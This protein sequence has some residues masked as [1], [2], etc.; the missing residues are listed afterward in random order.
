MEPRCLLALDTAAGIGLTAQYFAG[1]DFQ[2][3]L[4]TRIES[5][6]TL[7]WGNGAPVAG[8]NPDSFSARLTGQVEA[9]VTEAHTFTLSADGGVRLWVNGIKHIDRWNDLFVTGATATVDLISGRR[10]DIQ[11]EFRDTSGAANVDLKWS[12]PSLS[13]QAIPTTSLFPAELGSV[14]RRVWNS[15]PGAN[16]SALTSLASFPNSPSAV[17]TLSTFEFSSTGSDSYGDLISGILH[18]QAT[19]NYRFFIAGDDSA[20]LWLSNTADPA[21]KQRIAFLTAATAVRDWTVNPSQQSALIPLVAGQQYAIEVIHKENTGADH[22]AVGW[23]LPGST[24]IDVIDGQFLSPLLALVR[25]FS[26]TDVTT[27]GSITPL[28]Y[29]VQRG[30]GPSTNPLVVSYILRGTATAELDYAVTS[31]TVTIPAGAN[32]A[33]VNVTTLND[34]DT[35]GSETVIFEVVDGLGYEVG[36]ISER[37]S[38]GT[39]QDVVAVPAGGIV[40]TATDTLANYSKFGGTFQTIT[41]ATPFSTAVQATI[42]AVLTNSYDAQLKLGFG[43]AVQQGDILF[44][45]FYVRSVTGSEGQIT[46]VSEK[47][48]SPYTK[49]L[50]QSFAVP[51]VWTHVQLPFTSLENYAAGGASFGFFLGSKAQTL[52]FTNVSV[53]NYGAARNITPTTVFLNNIGGTYGTSISVPVTGQPF[54]SAVQLDTVTT[55]DQ[56]FKLQYVGRNSAS[57]ATGSVLQLEY[58][59]RSLSGATPKVNLSI[60]EVGGAYTTLASHTENLTPTWTKYTLNVTTSSV[61]SIEG[62]QAAFNVGFAPQTIEIGGVKWTNT[63]GTIDLANLPS[64]SPTA[65][66]VGRTGDDPWRTT[67]DSRI[68]DVRKAT[69]TVNVVDAKGNPVDGAVVSVQQTQHAFRFGSAIDNN[70]GLLSTTGAG[71]PTATKYQSE[72]ERLFNTATIENSLK[73]PGYLQNPARALEAANWVR[74]NGLLLRGH[75]IIW[76]SRRN[77]PSSVWAQYDSIK[78]A[79][80]DAAAADYLRNTAATRVQDAVTAFEGFAG[81]WDV[82][83]EP[84]DNFDVMTILGNQIVVDWFNQVGTLSPNT[85]RVLN[86]YAIFARNGNNTA[87]RASFDYRLGLLKSNDGNNANDAV[88]RIGE[89]SHYDEGNLT[90]IAVLG[91]LIDSYYTQFDLPIAITEFTIS[92]TDKQLQADYL[93]DYLTMSFSQPAIDEFINWGFWAGAHYQADDA[94]YNLDFSIRPHGQV[95]EDLVFGEWW[96]D[97]R[98]TTRSGA[99]TTDVFKG[100]YTITVTLGD[101]VVTKTLADFSADGAT[102]LSLPGVVWSQSQFT[103]NEG[104]ALT[105]TAV[106][107]RA[108]TADVTVSIAS[109]AQV[110]VSP[111]QLIFTP[112]N[113]NLPQLVTITPVNDYTLEGP[114]SA[115]LAT[116]FSSSDTRF[117][118]AASD[119][120]AVDIVDGAAATQISKIAIGGGSSQRSRITDVTIEFDGPVSLQSGAVSVIKRGAGGG[121]VAATATAVADSDNRKYLVTFSGPFVQYGSLMD[122]NYE[123]S[124]LATSATNPSGFAIDGDQNGTPGGNY[125]WGADQLDKFFR[126]FGD[127]DG[128]R[129]VDA[130][131]LLNFR[132]SLNVL[133]ANTNYKDYFDER[134]DLDVDALDL[135]SFR[136]NLNVP[137]AFE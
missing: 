52:Q 113:W 47:T 9:A 17:S 101:Q 35:E 129:D 77:M 18:P 118:S 21:G 54:T 42:P 133:P 93:R 78:A 29:V 137:F 58:Y 83:N 36:L 46:A 114:Q 66:Y 127:G 75:N 102:T 63:S 1:D 95:Y 121:A 56:S 124:I 59:A 71:G 10:Y 8:L 109:T 34:A 116:T 49:S 28:S 120:L 23:T 117:G 14:Q 15:L 92:S 88:E 3:I 64:T 44:A 40:I 97:T 106:L 119:S 90:D 84:F 86:D 74:D 68:D 81:E 94:L 65:S 87:H 100:D 62:L 76:P 122:G 20:E 38:L 39:I 135:L 105:T 48:S 82:V 79:Q 19:G 67:A 53:R 134:H 60:Q 55:P 45:D 112:T 89:Q 85:Q 27:E 108:P 111:Q 2:S 99:L 80:G 24:S 33:T 61:Y 73:W 70:N 126:R 125:T 4:Q 98:G 26:Q 91:Q 115:V 51:T 96:T 57:V 107:S 104:V 13:L 12:S 25:V 7:D 50:E 132:R 31:G 103:G 69:L 123:L 22:V 32:S 5:S 128:D 72:I 30:G 6:L 130:L 11:L 41:P 136:R 43:A 16:L 110:A 131:D 37:R